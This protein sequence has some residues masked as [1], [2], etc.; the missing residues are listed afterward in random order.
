MK[1]A[2]A[3]AM[4]HVVLVGA[5]SLLSRTALGQ[6]IPQCTKLEMDN[7]LLNQNVQACASGYT[8]LLPNK[9]CESGLADQ[10]CYC[11]SPVSRTSLGATRE[12]VS[13]LVVF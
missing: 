10:A 6:K 3:A 5:L 13:D 7:L 8:N 4:S 1:Q 11:H 9:G 12:C 2:S